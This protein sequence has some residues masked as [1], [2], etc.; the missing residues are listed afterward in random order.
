MLL[1]QSSRNSL[2][3]K[4]EEEFSLFPAERSNELFEWGGCAALV[5]GDESRGEGGAY[6]RGGCVRG[7]ALYP[8]AYACLGLPGS[9]SW[10][11]TT[12]T[13]QGASTS[14][15]CVSET[16]EPRTHL[17]L[18]LDQQ[19]TQEGEGGDDAQRAGWGGAPRFWVTTRGG[20][21][22]RGGTTNNTREAGRLGRQRDA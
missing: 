3:T 7:F 16:I 13:S 6:S 21:G 10:I 20:E 18:D 2:R 4:N 22:L 8:L 9:P 1:K 14:L 5:L 15:T 11:T 12:T 19:H 17:D